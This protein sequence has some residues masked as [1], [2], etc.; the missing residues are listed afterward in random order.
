MT[1]KTDLGRMDELVGESGEPGEGCLSYT[2]TVVTSA[3]AVIMVGW[4]VFG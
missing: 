4:L 3:I 1:K 2:L